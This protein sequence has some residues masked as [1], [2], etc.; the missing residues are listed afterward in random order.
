MTSVERKGT[1]ASLAPRTGGQV[2]A[3][4]TPE[5][6]DLE[7]V[8][9]DASERASAFLIDAAII[10]GVLIGVTL[11]MF[12]AG[13][14]I[15]Q[16]IFQQLIVIVWLLGFF[17]LRNLYFVGFELRIGA[18]TPGKRL[19]GLRVASRG[20]EALSADAVFARNAMRELEVYLPLS[21]LIANRTGVDGVIVA[22]GLIWAGV[23]ALFPLFNRDRLRAGDLVAGTWVVRVPKRRLGAELAGRRAAQPGLFT[24]SS[25][26]LD[27][28][29]V[30]ELQ[31]LEDVLRRNNAKTIADVADRIRTKI[32]WPRAPGE[33]D[34]DFLDAYYTGLRENLETR[35]L[36]GRRRRD[37]HDRD[38]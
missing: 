20:G 9:A 27:A 28:Y 30:K 22:A 17:V 35:L 11:I 14:T 23:F 38:A 10:V 25:H 36:F 19:L 15:H 16:P 12:I 33:S 13:V 32:T 6:V 34:W 24:F 26:Q 21:F 37:K 2:R 4:V 7:L 18:A 3:L 31:V 29:G 5:G 8:L 1:G